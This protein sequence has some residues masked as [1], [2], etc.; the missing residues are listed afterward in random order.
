MRQARFSIGQ[1]IHHRL[2]DYRGVIID[3]DAVFQGTDAWYEQVATTRPPKNEPWYRVLVHDASHETYVAERNLE[4][5]RTPAPTRWWISFLPVSVM[6][7][8]AAPEEQTR[9]WP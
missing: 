8:T 2:F 3:V 5:D 4:A 1:C 6:A 9:P 7:P